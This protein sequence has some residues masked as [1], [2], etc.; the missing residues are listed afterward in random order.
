MLHLYSYTKRRL[1]I[2]SDHPISIIKNKYG[3]GY[4]ILTSIKERESLPIILPRYLRSL[5]GYKIVETYKRKQRIPA[6][7]DTK[8]K[9]SLVRTGK[10]RPVSSNLKTSK[11]M[12][13][14]SNFEGK[15]HNNDTKAVMSE[16][17]MG[18][19]RVTGLYWC[20][21]P[22]TGQERRVRDRNDLPN[23]FIIGR[24]YDSVEPI[25]LYR[26]SLS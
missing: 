7:E 22:I 19:Q 13:G 12:A 25:A 15:R 24:D 1:L 26:K 5:S 23:G 16:K 14:K 8:K 21:N 3:H 17:A 4:E 6:T 2:I 20:H 18:N 11:T 9:I 10:P